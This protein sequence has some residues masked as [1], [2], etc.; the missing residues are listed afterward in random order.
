ML[1]VA[2]LLVAAL[3]VAPAL[4]ADYQMKRAFDDP[5][6]RQ[7]M[8]SIAPRVLSDSESLEEDSDSPSAT[9]FVPTRTQ[10][11]AIIDAPGWFLY[12]LTRHG[13]YSPSIALKR[14]FPF[15]EFADAGVLYPLYAIPFWW[16]LGRAADA[17]RTL[18]SATPLR[19][20]WWDLVLML[21][22]VWNGFLGWV[23]YIHEA[24]HGAA[25]SCFGWSFAVWGVWGL[26]PVAVITVLILQ[27]KRRAPGFQLP[28][29]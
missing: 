6:T 9:H 26:A 23:W 15:D 27:R 4:V 25:A 10:A 8:A 2:Q 22:L 17:G 21:P 29:N 1:P 16:V 3:F 18:R 5:G 7:L 12:G 28:V 19:L 24:A 13:K 11:V 14:S 20:R